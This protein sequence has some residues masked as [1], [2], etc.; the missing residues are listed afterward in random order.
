MAIIKCPECG[1]EVSSVAKQCVHC[2]F[3]ILDFVQRNAEQ[4]NNNSV[5]NAEQV[6]NEIVRRYNNN[7]KEKVNM[8]KNFREK[9]GMG[10]KESEQIIEL[11]MKQIQSYYNITQEKPPFNGI[12]KYTLFGGKQEVYCKRCRSA[13]CSH[14][15]EKKVIPG[16]TKTTYSANLNPL[17]PFTVLNKKEKVVRRDIEYTENRIIC[18][19][20]GFIFS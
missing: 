6:A 1:K 3:P 12:Y 9:T 5:F 17:K 10:L 2:G 14:Y 20:C 4:Q 18:N 16:K 19:D 7:P 15:K 11:A 8:I 13:N